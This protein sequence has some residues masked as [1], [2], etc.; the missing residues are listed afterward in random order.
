MQQVRTSNQESRK[1]PTQNPCSGVREWKKEEKKKKL[2]IKEGVRM[3]CTEAL[4][5]KNKVGR[6]D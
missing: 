3:T 4:L 5:L 6:R 1:K 2:V